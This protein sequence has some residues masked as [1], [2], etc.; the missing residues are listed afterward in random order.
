MGYN[1]YC[2]YMTHLIFT[3]IFTHHSPGL[4]YALLLKCVEEIAHAQSARSCCWCG[5]RSLARSC[6]WRGCRGRAA[7]STPMSTTTATTLP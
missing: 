3:M 5:S 2:H 7:L 1:R 4:C 6:S